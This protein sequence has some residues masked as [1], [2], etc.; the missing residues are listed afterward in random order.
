MHKSL[1][2]GV[3]LLLWITTAVLSHRSFMGEAEVDASLA[4]QAWI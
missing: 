3:V 4:L 1:L 2:V